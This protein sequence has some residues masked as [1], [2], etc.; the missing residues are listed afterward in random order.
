LLAAAQR[1]Q[2]RHQQTKKREALAGKRDRPVIDR[3]G[4]AADGAFHPDNERPNPRIPKA[5]KHT[6][7]PKTLDELKAADKKAAN[8]APDRAVLASDLF[9]PVHEDNGKLAT[10]EEVLD[11][12]FHKVGPTPALNKVR[13]S[14]L[15]LPKR[16]GNDPAVWGDSCRVPVDHYYRET[17]ATKRRKRERQKHARIIVHRPEPKQHDHPIAIPDHGTQPRRQKPQVMDAMGGALRKRK[18]PEVD[19]HRETEEEFHARVL[20]QP[21]R[22]EVRRWVLVLD[23]GDARIRDQLSDTQG[24]REW[25]IRDLPPGPRERLLRGYEA[26]VW[27]EVAFMRQHRKWAKKQQRAQKRRLTRT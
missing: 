7:P 23:W 3:G 12:R 2:Q 13:R 9:H 1:D 20:G 5:R 4:F 17:A 16:S 18:G 22:E 25:M 26:A 14:V 15:K 19:W 24:D 27:A 6:G 8:R 10:N 21:I 11:H